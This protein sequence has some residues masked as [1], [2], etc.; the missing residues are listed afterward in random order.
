MK[1]FTCKICSKVYLGNEIPPTC[2]FCGVANKF[3]QLPQIW[4]DE[5]NVA[6]SEISKNNV[7]KA[8][9][10]ELS[11]TA[12]Y[13]SA[14]KMLTNTKAKLMFKGLAHVEKEHAKVFQKILKLDT[15]PVAQDLASENE[16]EC[17]KESLKREKSAVELYLK[18]ASEATELRV[19]EVFLAI[20]ETEKDHITLDEEIL[21]KS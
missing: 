2:P 4:Q 6:L 20:M 7:E 11:N 14:S 18:A 13:K 10:I 8:L 3:F 21:S 15:L 12:F 19:K 17:V 5:N 9:K 16:K 1:I